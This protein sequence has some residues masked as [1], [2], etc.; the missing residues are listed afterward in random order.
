MTL[1]LAWQPGSL[2]DLPAGTESTGP[3][4]TL[5]MLQDRALVKS[6]YA[7]GAWN[8]FKACWAREVL[9]VSRNLFLYGFRTVQ[10]IIIAV[11]VV[12]LF[13]HSRMPTKTQNDGGKFF[14]VLFFSLL[15]VLFD[16]EPLA[17]CMMLCCCGVLHACS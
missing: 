15:I 16:G 14:S 11:V 2:G 17:P 3:S 7:L 5:R 12:L 8:M 1:P 10:T 6:K 4:L 9:L 13:F